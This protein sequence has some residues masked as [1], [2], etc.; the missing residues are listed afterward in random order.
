MFKI[1]LIREQC[2]AT[3]DYTSLDAALADA[4]A[5]AKPCSI[6][7]FDSGRYVAILEVNV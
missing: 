2:W 7:E 5:L 3:G 1:W 4:E 6:Q